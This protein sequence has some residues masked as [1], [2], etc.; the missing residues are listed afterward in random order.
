MEKE[1][2]LPMYPDSKDIPLPTLS[3]KIRVYAEY[4]KSLF[5]FLSANQY[6]LFCP[7]TKDFVFSEGLGEDTLSSVEPIAVVCKIDRTITEIDF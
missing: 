3:Y 4:S 5:N 2:I 1:F 6:F 7:T